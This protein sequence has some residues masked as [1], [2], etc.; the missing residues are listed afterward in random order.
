MSNF[1]RTQLLGDLW[2]V[3]LKRRSEASAEDFLFANRWLEFIQ[4]QKILVEL[5]VDELNGKL[6]I[7]PE[8]K[9]L[10][11]ACRNALQ[12]IIVPAPTTNEGEAA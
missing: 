4:E 6:I 9:E 7:R 5:G 3:A 1:F 10:M 11:E 2:S 8:D 12:G